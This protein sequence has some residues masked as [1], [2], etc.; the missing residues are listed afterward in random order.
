MSKEL[1]NLNGHLETLGKELNKIDFFI[2]DTAN[3][4]CDELV[5][6][7]KKREDL[8][9]VAGFINHVIKIE[10]EK[11]KKESPIIKMPNA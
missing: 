2:V 11:N 3:I 5:K 10:E 8:L 7:F 6:R 4:S 1:Q 9:E